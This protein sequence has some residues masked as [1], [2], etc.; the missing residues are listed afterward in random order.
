VLQAE[1]GRVRPPP[2][3][4]RLPLHV[5]IIDLDV[6]QGN[7]TARI[8]ASDPS[9]FT[10]SMHGANNFPFAK[11]RSDLDVALPDGDG[12]HFFETLKAERGASHLSVIFISARS[13]TSAKVRALKL[14][15]VQVLD[16]DGKPVVP[17]IF[18]AVP[19]CVDLIG[20]PYIE[21]REAVVKAFRPKKK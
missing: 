5:A 11:E 10:L 14:G 3:Q 2:G 13:D 1:W 4:R 16:A 17:G 21:T 12:F 18:A 19:Y 20:G 9:V 7:G 6:H 8:F 15:E